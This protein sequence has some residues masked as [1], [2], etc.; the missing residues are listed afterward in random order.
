M[1]DK[2]VL[3]YGKEKDP[4][5]KELELPVDILIPGATGRS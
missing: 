4:R 1:G 5:G 2:A 3:K